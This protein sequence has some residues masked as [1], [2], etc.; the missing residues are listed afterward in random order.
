MTDEAIER[1]L[2]TGVHHYHVLGLSLPTDATAL[3]PSTVVRRRYKELAIRVHPDKNASPNAEEAFKRLSEAY[4]CLANEHSQRVY[5]VRL[6]AQT[7]ARRGAKRPRPPPPRAPSQ[8]SKPPPP[9]RRPKRPKTSPSPPPPPT[10][11]PPPRRRTPEEIWQAFQ[12]EEEEQARREFHAKGFEREYKAASSPKPVSNEHDE[13]ERTRV[14]ESALDDKA[15]R[16]HGWTKRAETT[17]ETQ[18]SSPPRVIC[19]LLCR[20]KFPSEAA[21]SRHEELST[22]HRENVAKDSAQ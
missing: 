13:A 4:E 6:L 1:I 17:E 16:W 9:P 15:S 11:P 18:T 21:L 3:A 19:C 2:S 10:P 14:L 8:R 22:L 20:R 12:R 5:L 7:S